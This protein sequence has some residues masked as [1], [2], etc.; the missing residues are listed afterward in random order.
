VSDLQLRLQE[1]ETVMQQ[2]AEG[3]DFIDRV[4]VRLR[5]IDAEEKKLAKEKKELQ[6]DVIRPALLDGE[7][8]GGEHIKGTY[9]L[10][11]RKTETFDW[12]AAVMN[13]LFTL[14]QAEQFIK[15]S[16]TFALVF[17]PHKEGQ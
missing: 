10:Q 12:K 1:P 3:L 4:A 14:E 2:A 8:I 11:P 7:I 9:E 17:K 15:R 13:H 5:E 6:E 16:E